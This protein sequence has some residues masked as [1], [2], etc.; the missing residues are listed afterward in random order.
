M[1]NIKQ[2]DKVFLGDKKTPFRAVT[3]GKLN[4]EVAIGV[5]RGA[6][7]KLLN[8]WIKEK[9]RGT[10]VPVT[11]VVPI[12]R[13]IPVEDLVRDTVRRGWRERWQQIPLP[14]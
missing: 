9:A 2:G 14:L 6:D 11:K 7:S 8:D 5:C 10:K 1:V 4:G 13:W 3:L 12:A